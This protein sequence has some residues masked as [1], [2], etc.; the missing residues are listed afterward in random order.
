MRNI[1]TAKQ[2]P[3]KTILRQARLRW[4]GIILSW[5]EDIRSIKFIQW[6][7]T[8]LWSR[9]KKWRMLR[10]IKLFEMKRSDGTYMIWNMSHMMCVRDGSGKQMRLICGKCSSA[11]F[12]LLAWVV[13]WFKELLRL[14][15]PIRARVDSIIV[16]GVMLPP[17]DAFNGLAKTMSCLYSLHYDIRRQD[18]GV[19]EQHEPQQRSWLRTAVK[20]A[21]IS[22]S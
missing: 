19:E 18:N 9:H 3:G 8:L 20:S 12:E 13:D 21:A 6:W 10:R 2:H 4:N 17:S 5:L 15:R 16:L 11:L 7:S 22:C 14:S 1:T